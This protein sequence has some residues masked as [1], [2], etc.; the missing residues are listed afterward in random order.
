MEILADLA[1]SS[2]SVIKRVLPIFLAATIFGQQ[3]T[4]HLKNVAAIAKEANGAVV[5]IVMADKGGHP[6]AQG[7]GF[8][9]TRN[10]R[11][12]TTYGLDAHACQFFHRAGL[13]SRQE[14]DVIRGARRI[15][16]VVELTRDGIGAMRTSR[17]VRDFR[18]RKDPKF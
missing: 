4:T 17:E 1:L 18:H 2:A 9:V 5:S 15:A 6:I 3:S 13:D 7:S 10:G 14:A 8:V 12:V 16:A 11:V